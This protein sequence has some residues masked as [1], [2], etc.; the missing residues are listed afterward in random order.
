MWNCSTGQP[1]LRA[2]AVRVLE[3]T[4]REGDRHTLAAANI[5]ISFL[6]WH[7]TDLWKINLSI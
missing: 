5:S 1:G 4:S 6:P 2:L 3:G 7:C